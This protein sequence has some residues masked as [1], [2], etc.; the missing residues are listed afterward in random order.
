MAGGI[1]IFWR[2]DMAVL[3]SDG[4]DWCRGGLRIRYM[5]EERKLFPQILWKKSRLFTSIWSD[6]YNENI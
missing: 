6:D 2:V 4:R 1:K 3:G 5:N